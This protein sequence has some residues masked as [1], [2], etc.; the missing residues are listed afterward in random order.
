MDALAFWAFALAAGAVGWPIACR[1][2]RRFPDSGAGLAFPVGM[3]LLGY[4]YFMLRTASVVPVGRGGAVL[5]LGLAATVACAL[6]A[7]DRR[8]R[9]T[10]ARAAPL[11]VA[12]AG[13]FTILFFGY[14]AFR[15]YSSEILL[16]SEQTMDLMYLNA[17]V[18]SPEYP[19]ADGWL[20]GERAS[21]YYF[22]YVQ[23][24]VLT[25]LAGLPATTGYNLSLAY[26]FAAAGTS[27]VSLGMALARWALP[28]PR[29]RLAI[30][31]GGMAAGLL[32]LAGT[33]TAPFELAAAHGH[34]NES[35]YKAAGLEALLPC[36][37]G[38][39]ATAECY[40][41]D[42]DRSSAWYPT[43]FYFWWRG[44]RIIPNTIT[45]FP[46]FSFLLGDLHPH[47]MSIP[48]TFVAM[49]FAA[50][51]WRGRGALSFASHRRSPAAFVALSVAFGALAFANAWDMPAF[52][53]LFALAVVARNVRCAGLSGAWRP[54]VSYL[55]PIFA[56]AVAGYLPWYADFSSQANGFHAYRGAG[57]IPAHVVWQWG[58][59]LA[60]AAA[61]LFTVMRQ[62][63]L[64]AMATPLTYAAWLP[65]APMLLWIGLL[66]PRASLGDAVDAR[67]AGGWLTLVTYG[68]AL[69][70]LGAAT[71]HLAARR[72]TVAPL[73]GLATVG[74]LLLYGAELFYIGDV[75]EGSVPRLNTV[76]KLSYQAWLLLSAAGGAG[77][78]VALSDKRA[79]SRLAGFGAAAVAVV[80]LT[81]AVIA[82]PNRSAAFATPAS[83]DGLAYLSRADPAEYELTRWVE[84]N[85]GRGAIVIEATGRRWGRNAD[86]APTLLDGNS[87]YSETGRIA[88]RAGTRA[89]IG[90]YFHEIQWRGASPANHTEFTRRQDLVDAIYL[91][92]DISAALAKLAE[93]G[94][95]LVIA[96]RFEQQMYGP[97]G[98]IDFA[99]F[100]DIVFESGGLRVYAVP[101]LA[102]TRTS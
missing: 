39:P 29:R 13:L 38:Q 55:G 71:V 31:G 48:L 16:H 50:S 10:S 40:R 100:L 79:A 57:T 9:Q 92:E 46:F 18:N 37:A 34:T 56:L 83:I 63:G 76:F 54:T 90:Q 5:V 93:A 87:D 59:L 20:A 7:R 3:L 74:V 69:T 27:A 35:V 88:A 8:F 53:A 15:S 80:S 11:A 25:S 61:L 62:S 60:A 94:A 97:A 72:Q 68:A 6:A 81:Y 19:P 24:G 95:R 77:I 102:P 67:G 86:G 70:V 23:A 44:T 32:L 85:A 82:T 75:F 65:L 98:M 26:T 99:A 4:G 78:I 58:V 43:E 42:A 22:G 41:G 89:L 52:S 45:E 66:L 84:A 49:A 12:M 17:A 96:G 73:L 21:Y 47:L 51:T 33:L 36:S 2:F 91:S 30:A 101:T 1:A 64:R 14:A 28:R